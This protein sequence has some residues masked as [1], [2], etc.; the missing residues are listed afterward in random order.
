MTKRLARLNTASL[1]FRL[2]L[3]HVAFTFLCMSCYG[4]VLSQYLKHELRASREQTMLHR[5]HR[6]LSFVDDPAEEYPGQSLQSK[7]RHF[8]E[9]SPDSDLIEVLDS[10]GNRI[11]PDTNPALPLPRARQSCL[12][13][14]LT[15]FRRDHHQ[16]RLLTHQTTIVGRPVW[17]LMSGV[18]DEHDDILRSVRTGYFVLLPLVLLGSVLGGYWMSRR[19]LQPVGRLTESATRISLTS[20]DGR[21]PVPQTRDELQSL[22]EAWN[23]LLVRLEAE[24]NR[25]TRF[26]TDIS[27]DLRSAMT[28]ILANAE[29]GLRRVRTPESYR[30]TLA[31]I[32]QESNH[33]L[34]MLEDMLLAARSAGASQ[35]IDKVPVCFDHL[36]AEIYAASCAA[37]S[38]KQQTLRLE[39]NRGPELWVLGDRSLMRR[40]LNSLIDNAIKYT[41]AGGLIE[42]S[43][44]EQGDSFRLS[45]RDS[46]IG[47]P[48]E[49]KDR[50]FD[51]LFRADAA[52]S[53]KDLPGS[54][55][56]LS[57][58]KWIADVHGFRIELDSEPNRGSTFTVIM[59]AQARVFVNP[60]AS[61]PGGKKR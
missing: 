51:R 14:C 22:A 3:W 52:R 61:E 26:T 39:E 33:V 44:K 30:A 43:Y 23:D 10:S 31:A 27:H 16:W 42:L 24:V 7:I 38:I 57:I 37:S 9:A 29:L 8:S 28:V 40:M 46:G 5:E 18:T 19:A 32:Q 20:L 6:F 49:L 2:S 1:R 56:G 35:V 45:V 60:D 11:Y 12:T 53:R 47:I 58:V 54:G 41:P 17:L 48:A 25:S 34:A 36:V 21:L 50:V 59:P 55:L 15:T 13:P 4:V